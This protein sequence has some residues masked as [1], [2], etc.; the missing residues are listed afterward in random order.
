[1]VGGERRGIH[2]RCTPLMTNYPV[3]YLNGVRRIGRCRWS[4]MPA[5]KAKDAYNAERCVILEMRDA[6][7]K[8]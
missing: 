3:G 1:M 8:C 6:L 2:P 5:V 4:E 7:G